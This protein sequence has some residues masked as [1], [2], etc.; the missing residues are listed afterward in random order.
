MSAP[1]EPATVSRFE[2]NLLRLLRAVVTNAPAEQTASLVYSKLTAPPCLGRAAVRLA[3]DT[4]AKGLVLYLTR[5]GGWRRERFVR[6]TGAATGR[7][8]DRVPLDERALT[9]SQH[10][11]GFLVWLTA[12]KP[13]ECK[14]PW[15]APPA[16]LTAGDELFLALAL[17]SLRPLADVG[18]VLSQRAA[19]RQNPLAW[20][21]APGD[22]VTGDEPTP[23]SF[24]PWTT[25][26]RAAILECLQPVL[27]ARWLAGER[28]KG[29]IC[30]WKRMRQQGQAEAATLASFLV[31]CEAAGRPDLARF[32]LSVAKA[33]L[34]AG[35]LT[36]A[37]WTGGLQGPGPARLADRLATQRA[38]LAVP[39][40]LETLQRWDRQARAVG[41]FDEGYEASQ[42]WKAEWEAAGGDELTARARRLLEQLE[43]LRTG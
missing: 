32:L 14:E 24:E 42:V 17:D 33:I 12:E 25:G 3:E 20:L 31:A 21:F 6:G 29:Q 9:F 1:A 11:L 13:A 34:P 26:T 23:P 16:E 5:A 18:P 37:Y 41:Y 10:T 43:P 35:E 2:Y 8:W 4:L 15:D 28:S 30:E 40:Q 39:R 19:A 36:P 22:F 27:A 7:V 38:A